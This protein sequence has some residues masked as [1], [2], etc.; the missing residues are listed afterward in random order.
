MDGELLH[1]EGISKHYGGVQALRNASLPVAAGE[2]HAL[3][4]ENGAGK[5]T[6]SKIIAGA[7]PASSGEI[8]WD[9]QAVSIDTPMSAQRLGISMIYQELDLF[10]NLT[11]AENLVIG[12]LN[13]ERHQWV[14]FEQMDEFCRSFLASANV[15]H[16]LRELLGNLPIG[17]RQL[18]AVA[19][20][21][22]MG[23]RLIF[24]DEPTSALS[25]DGAAILFERIQ[26]IK[27]RGVSVVYISHKMPEIFRIS[28]RITVLRDGET[29]GT[30]VTQETN[31]EE[32]IA[33]MVGRTLTESVRSSSAKRESPPLLRVSGLTT[34]KLR[35]VSFDVHR[36]EVLGIAGLLGAGKSEL[37]AA[38]FGLDRIHSGQVYVKGEPVQIRSPRHAM[39][40]GFGL[41]P[42]DRRLEGLMMQMSV[43]EN[44]TIAVLARFST[45]GFIRTSEEA[46]RSGQIL[47]SV[48]LKTH[49][50]DAPVST[51]SGGNQQKVLLAKWLLT[52][53]D[54]LVLDDPNRGVDVGAKWDI[55]GIIDSL[56]A[57]GK[58]IV[59]VSSELPEL[60]RCCDR[61]LVLHEGRSMGIVDASTTTQEEIMSRATATVVN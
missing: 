27:R 16:S 57:Q 39:A 1:A 61:I 21:L 25:E 5:S 48:K 29:V 55:Y 45:A 43:R 54:I 47:D 49:S 23:S 31:A 51:L 11:V 30:R 58:A 34:A 41:L 60:V 2:V 18:V 44:S 13:L 17:Q 7:L 9:G 32:I 24:M 59:L 15:R 46:A 12:N 14:D 6:L 8:R 28:D 26:E 3:V 19:R 36:G 38:L 33:M 52:E 42:E 10:P 35:D 4:G 56:A 37:G 22:S 50:P 20:A 53:P 40:L